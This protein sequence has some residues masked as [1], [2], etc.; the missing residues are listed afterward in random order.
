MDMQKR[1]ARLL[2]MNTAIPIGEPLSDG[3]KK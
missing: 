1:F 2:V 3:F